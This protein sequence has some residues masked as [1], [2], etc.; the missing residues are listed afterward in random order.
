MTSRAQ[1]R[2]PTTGPPRA[3]RGARSASGYAGGMEGASVI[4]TIGRTP[5]TT[6]IAAGGRHHLTADEPS[7]LGGADKGANPYELL[8]ASLG[9]CKAITL[10]MYA[11]RKEWP[12]DGVSVALKQER[13]HAKDCEDCESGEGYVHV[14]ECELTL[15]G[16]DLSSEQRNRLLEIADKCP[17]HRTLSGEIKMRTSL[18]EDG[19]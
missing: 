18:A 8:L 14:I 16:D 13:V 6:A 19:A 12:L 2:K 15:L 10:R 3:E 5:Y 9:A 7:S 11:D 4:T 17:V 1:P